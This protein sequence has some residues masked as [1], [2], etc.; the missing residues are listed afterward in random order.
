MRA[1]LPADLAAEEDRVRA[2]VGDRRL[3]V[4]WP[5]GGAGAA[6]SADEVARLGAWAREHDVVLG[7]REPRVDRR[8]GWTRALS[9][10]GALSL[11]AR[12]VPWSTVVHRVA[13]AVVTDRSPEA[14][15][16]LVTGTPLL[17]QA[18]APGPTQQVEA[19][20]PG[21]GW[22]LPRTVATLDD[23]LDAL[24]EVAAGGW[25]VAPPAGARPGVAPLD[26]HAAWRF[27]QRVRGLSLR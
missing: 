16:A 25:R 6:Y 2:L 17:V 27:A 7:V 10:A 12:S 24:S 5:H 8:D 26:G 11:S 4:W 9:D 14:Y 1:H 21:D 15:D 13:S 19:S 23:L 20:C 22:P 3:V 18:P